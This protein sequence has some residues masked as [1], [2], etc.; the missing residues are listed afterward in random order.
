MQH[1]DERRFFLLGAT[2]I[3]ERNY[4]RRGTALTT[5]EHRFFTEGNEGKEEGWQHTD[6]RRFF[7]QE[8]TEITETNCR[9]RGNALS[10]DEH[11]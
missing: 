7:L 11:R 5:D 4:R 9:R 1:T 10:T 6:E 2:E 3:G 8:A